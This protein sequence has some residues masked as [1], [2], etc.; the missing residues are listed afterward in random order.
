M[1]KETE[2][3]TWYIKN[4]IL[5]ISKWEDTYTWKVSLSTYKNNEI[6]IEINW[7]DDKRNNILF[8][9]NVEIISLFNFS[10]INQDILW[11][12][13]LIYWIKRY[14]PKSINLVLPYFPYAEKNLENNFI[15]KNKIKINTDNWMLSLLQ[16]SWISTI[17]TFDLWNIYF[18][19]YS[20]FYVENI[21]KDK[22]FI[23]E[24]DFFARTNKRINIITL[25]Q[26]DYSLFSKLFWH[27]ENISI[28]YIDKELSLRTK[29]EQVNIFSQLSEW[30]KSII[31]I[32][33]NSII[34]GNRIYALLNLLWNNLDIKELNLCV[35]HWIFAQWSYRKYNTL[36]EKF[37]YMYITTTNSILWYAS[38][39]Y[40]DR[41]SLIKLQLVN[42]KRINEIKKRN[43]DDNADT[44]KNNEIN[45]DENKEIEQ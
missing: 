2:I 8:D 22:I 32:F 5:I 31:Y 7:V 9:S 24:F 29:N 36:L 3:G 4:I 28:I 10:N 16:N 41:L 25:N 44:I 1:D 39:I 23:D 35:T 20:S 37:P 6:Q 12:L 30:G 27:K 42:K 33:D 19:N 15:E 13:L 26:S 38:K 45:E 11:L 21:S 40:E 14:S 18:Q 43:Q 34:R 17:K